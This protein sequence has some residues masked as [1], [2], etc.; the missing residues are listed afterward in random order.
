MKGLLEDEPN[1]TGNLEEKRE[2]NAWLER[3]VCMH[4]LFQYQ[5]IRRWSF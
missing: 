1:L 3:S 5:H 2:R 4:C